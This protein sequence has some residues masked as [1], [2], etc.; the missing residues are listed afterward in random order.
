[1]FMTNAKWLMLCTVIAL[2]TGCS[3]ES[4]KR[5][6]QTISMSH[7]DGRLAI[8][9]LAHDIIHVIFEPSDF[10]GTD[11]SLVVIRDWPAVPFTVSEHGDEIVAETESLRLRVIKSSALVA[12]ERLDGEP[13]IQESARTLRPATVAEENVFHAKQQW[14]ISD[15]EG[16]YGLG[17]HQDGVM[18]Y[19]GHDV[20]LVQTNTVAVNPF[21][22]STKGYGLLWDNTSKTIFS[23]KES[24]ASFWS[25]VADRI[26]YYV[27]AGD[28]IDDVIA[29]YREATGQAPMLG[30]WAYGYWQSKERYRTSDELMSVVREYRERQIPIDNIVQDWNYWADYKP[31]DEIATWESAS[32]NWSS[33]SFHPSTYPDPSRLIAEIQNDYHMHYM[34]SIWPALGPAT[35]VYRELDAAG[36]LYEPEH[37]STGRIYDAFSEDAR[38]IYWKYL[39]A[40]L[41]D[42]GVDALWMDGTEPEL[43]DQHLVEVSESNIKRFGETARGSMAKNLN[44]YSLMTTSGAYENFRRDVPDKRFFTLTRSAFAGQQRNA[45]AT[46][47]GDINARFDVFRDQISSGVNFSMA[48]IPY[49]TT[50]IGAFFI[51]GTDKGKGPA[52][53]P[54]GHTDPSYRELYVRWFQ[55]GAFSPLFRSHGTGTP[56]EVW[57]FGEPGDWAYEA[58]VRF[59]HLRYRLL[60]YIYSTA[61]RVTNEGYTLM[62]GLPMDFTHDRATFDIDNQYLFGPSMMVVPVTEHQYFPL[63]GAADS[64]P[65][66]DLYLPSQTDWYDFW[67]GKRYQGGQTISTPTPID[68]MPIL[69]PA[70]SIIPLGPRKQWATEK[71]EDPI[72]LRIYPGADAEFVLYEDENDGYDYE[73]GVYA[74]IPIQW[75]DARKEFTLGERSGSFPG[76][77]RERTFRVVVVSEQQGT[78]D[79]ETDGGVPIRYSGS[80]VSIVLPSDADEG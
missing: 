8:E 58:L 31:G 59:D 48:G 2:T 78:G 37:W 16:L 43:G 25:E 77:L 72:E 14:R 49:W 67:S 27:I 66:I 23:D 35:D 29:G 50:D 63:E 42:K 80:A 13:L 76:M 28:T 24:G 38:D 79:S 20:T 15:Q 46:W 33:L 55:F 6:G 30:K 40:G 36:H 17:Q 69:V 22:V 57:R 68:E 56:R 44:A 32:A 54:K 61:W 60:P 9:I 70:G 39:K 1:M 53:Y 11:E 73:Q 4:F 65:M 41:I 10:D 5:E 71:Q 64:S 21:L 34:I 62:R 7:E 3:N 75:D 19:R 47:T 26:D 18:N 12:F 74:T 45:A 52:L 51:E